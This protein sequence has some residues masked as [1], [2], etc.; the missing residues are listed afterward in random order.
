MGLTRRTQLLIDPAEYS[1]LRREARRRKTTV[2]D[3]I[4]T[5]YR[6]VYFTTDDEQRERRRKAFDDFLSIRLPFTIEWDEAKQILD[7]RYDDVAP[8]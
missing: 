6:K 2:A 4:R 1:R 7:S 3:L 8:E 5:A